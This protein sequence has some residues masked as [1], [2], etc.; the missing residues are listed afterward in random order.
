MTGTDEQLYSRFL[1]TGDNDVLSELLSRHASSLTLFL[2]GYV[3]DMEDAEDLM[4]DSFAAAISGTSKFSGKSSF[5]TWLFSIGRNQA[6]T[7]L[8]RKK[9]KVELPEDVP[10]DPG[11]LPELVLLNEEQNRQLYKALA[12]LKTEYRQVLY[13]L[14]FQQMSYEE[15]GRVMKKSRKQMYHLVERGKKTLKEILE[16][17]G[18]KYE[19]K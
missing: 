3:H 1:S 7:H 14:Y 18:Y 8:R 2:Y 17:M 4:M 15:A 12:Q 13:L 10:A 6:H 5:K 16:G 11:K 19:D 9:P